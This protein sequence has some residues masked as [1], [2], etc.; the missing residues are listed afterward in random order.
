M[1]RG[2]N[3]SDRKPTLLLWSNDFITAGDGAGEICLLS[4]MLR[5]AGEL[6]AS[7]EN[8]SGNKRRSTANLPLEC[9]LDRRVIHRIDAWRHLRCVPRSVTC[10]QSQRAASRLIAGLP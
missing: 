2:S 7:I 8:G 4:V 1:Q 10:R 6:V 5:G 9:L 3:T